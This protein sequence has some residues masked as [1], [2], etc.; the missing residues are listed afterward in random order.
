MKHSG[1][2]PIL[3]KYMADFG[4]SGCSLAR[5]KFALISLSQR[6]DFEIGAPVEF[7]D[8]PNDSHCTRRPQGRR[9]V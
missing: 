5:S 9:G 7:R 4:R 1:V 2:Y 6:A 3:G 8:R